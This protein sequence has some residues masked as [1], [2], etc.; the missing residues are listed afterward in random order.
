MTSSSPLTRYSDSRGLEIG[1]TDAANRFFAARPG[2]S[3]PVPGASRR[4]SVSADW[5]LAAFKAFGHNWRD[6]DAGAFARIGASLLARSGVSV[7][8]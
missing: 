4:A 8:V 1:A 5:E 7:T 6:K 3:A 2:S